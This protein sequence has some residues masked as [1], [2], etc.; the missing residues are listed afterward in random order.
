VPT[1]S[2]LAEVETFHANLKSALDWSVDEPELGL[3]LVAGVARPWEDLGRA[4]EAM[5]AA[6]RLLVEEHALSHPSAWLEAAWRSRWLYFEARGGEALVAIAARVGEVAARVGDEYY[7]ALGRLDPGDMTGWPDALQLARDRGD[8]FEEALL[9]LTIASNTADDEPAAALPF[10]L[11]AERLSE[12]VGVRSLQLGASA[13]RV[14]VAAA[15]GQLA[16]AIAL[17]REI[18]TGPFSSAWSAGVRYLSH[19]GL[20]ARDD[21]A[22]RLAVELLDRAELRAPGPAEWIYNVRR[23][24]ALLSGERSAVNPAILD[25][26]SWPPSNGTLWLN[27][28]EAI[29]AGS[30]GDALLYARRRAVPRPHA[31]AALAAIEAAASGDEGRWHDA[32]SL[33]LAQGLHL[34]AVDA[35]EGLAATAARTESWVEALRLLGAAERLRDETGYRWRFRF[36]QA[37]VDD[38]RKTATAA[39]GETAAAAEADGRALERREAAAY[40]RR[41]RGERGRPQHGWASLTPTETQV[42]ALVAEGLT[43]PEI[44][45]RL[46]MGRAT[47]KTHLAHVFTK[48]GVHTRAELAAAVVRHAS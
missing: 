7:R 11:E 35:L 9:A 15:T 45:E 48:L 17:A 26:D 3:R 40:A 42:V 38:A 29:D 21:E 36:E 46:L 41:A 28:R 2:V 10:I 33:A 14:E 25:P 19:A 34:I 31:Q 37:A 16:S 23:R 32:L 5:A 47:V 43:N 6:D 22:L 30:A 18:V 13:T 24:A 8:R 1:D 20:L 4:P 44:A 12:A 27:S 39:L